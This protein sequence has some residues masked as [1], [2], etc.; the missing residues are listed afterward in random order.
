MRA[1]STCRPVREVAGVYLQDRHLSGTNEE[2]TG[3]APTRSGAEINPC[4]V[5]C[6][7][8]N[9]IL[10]S[11]TKPSEVKRKVAWLRSANALKAS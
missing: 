10:L 11:A 9:V 8:L 4:S 2:R 7:Y 6:F 3:F 1:I 5:G